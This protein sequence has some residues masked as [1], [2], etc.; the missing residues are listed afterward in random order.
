MRVNSFKTALEPNMNGDHQDTGVHALRR[1]SMV[2][3]LA[4]SFVEKPI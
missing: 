4:S 1:P 2:G 3:W